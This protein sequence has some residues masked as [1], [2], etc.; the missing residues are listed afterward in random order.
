MTE[1]Y[2]SLSI[3]WRASFSPNESKWMLI[4]WYYQLGSLL[5]AFENAELLTLVEVLN[6]NYGLGQKPSLVAL[7]LNAK[8]GLT[9]SGRRLLGEMKT[10]GSFIY[11]HTFI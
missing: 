4:C 2:C 1:Q 11:L 5:Y 7:D 6:G 10:N 8:N 3:V 9:K